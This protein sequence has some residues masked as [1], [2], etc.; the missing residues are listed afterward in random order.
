MWTQRE[1]SRPR[2]RPRRK[3]VVF[4]ATAPKVYTR[5]AERKRGPLGQ[6]VYEF[7]MAT[8]MKRS[9]LARKMYTS[10]QNIFYWECGHH[11][12]GRSMW[13]HFVRIRLPPEVAETRI[14]PGWRSTDGC[15]LIGETR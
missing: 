5:I 1:I 14:G 11:E 3:H 10:D 2:G 4:R 15:Y 13:A 8:R 12:P 9:D 7:R 6:Q